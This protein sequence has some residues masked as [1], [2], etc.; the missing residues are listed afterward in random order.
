MLLPTIK[1]DLRFYLVCLIFLSH[2]SRGKGF[3]FLNERENL[4]VWRNK[5]DKIPRNWT[6]YTDYALQNCLLKMFQ[7]K[8]TMTD[9]SSVKCLHKIHLHSESCE[10]DLESSLNITTKCVSCPQETVILYVKTTT[11]PTGHMCIHTHYNMLNISLNSHF[12]NKT[13]FYKLRYRFKAHKSLVFN[14]TFKIF[15]LSDFCLAACPFK[16]KQ[17]AFSI[18]TCDYQAGTEHLIIQQKTKDSQNDLF[19]CS[20][21]PQWSIYTVHMF[22]IEYSTC[23]VCSNYDSYIKFG[24]QIMDVDV[25]LTKSD[26]YRKIIFGPVYNSITCIYVNSLCKRH[27][28]MLFIRVKKIQEIFLKRRSTAFNFYMV[29]NINLN[30]ILYEIDSTKTVNYFFCSLRLVA[31]AEDKRIIQLPSLQSFS[32]SWSKRVQQ[33]VPGHSLEGVLSYYFYKLPEV[34]HLS[35]SLQSISFSKPQQFNKATRTQYKVDQQNQAI[36]I[37]FNSLTF[38]GLVVPSCLYGGLS[39]YELNQETLTLCDNYKDYRQKSAA[40]KAIGP[41][42]SATDDTTFVFYHD[43]DVFINV[44]L[45][46]SPTKCKGVFDNPC[47]HKFTYWHIHPR[48]EPVPKEGI[49]GWSLFYGHSSENNSCVAYQFG[50]KYISEISPFAENDEDLHFLTRMY[51]HSCSTTYYMMTHDDRAFKASLDFVHILSSH[52]SLQPNDDFLFE[53]LHQTEKMLS[54]KCN[55][56]AFDRPLNDKHTFSLSNDKKIQTYKT[57]INL[58]IKF[59]QKADLHHDSFSVASKPNSGSMYLLTLTLT[60]EESE[61]VQLPGG[62][63]SL[64]SFEEK[65]VCLSVTTQGNTEHRNIK[66]SRL[67]ELSLIGDFKLKNCILGT[68]HISTYLCLSEKY[69]VD[70]KAKD[71]VDVPQCVDKKSNM[72]E[73]FLVWSSNLTTSMMYFHGKRALWHLRGNVFDASF[74]YKPNSCCMSKMCSLEFRMDNLEMYN[75]YFDLFGNNKYKFYALLSRNVLAD[76]EEPKARSWY[77]ANKICTE[78]GRQLPTFASYENVEVLLHFLSKISWTV[79]VTNLFIGISKQVCIMS[80]SIFG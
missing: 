5:I 78:K 44:T 32:Y 24:Y 28:V 43:S 18:D 9:L 63:I 20:K 67:I 31:D 36:H 69:Y 13:Y 41:Y 8:K 56:S 72:G 10:N 55:L 30:H 33:W 19:Y 74:Y 58:K 79:M 48:P 59:S 12:L 75:S 64:S 51:A 76:Y 45:S 2:I 70:P 4:L 68:I 57:E 61:E 37:N 39:F 53:F 34:V 27:L 26:D 73:D 23:K 3:N 29:D 40:Y 60:T 77:E 15:D 25:M 35:K 17:A 65:N 38:K 21:R 71:F 62:I 1:N 46:F 66:H 16:P 14:I 54:N 11:K 7:F 50:L 22:Q 52:S 47:L 80:H 49:A 42:T 6:A